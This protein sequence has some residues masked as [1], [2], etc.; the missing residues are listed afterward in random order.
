[1]ISPELLRRYPFFSSLSEVQLAEI[2]MISEEV[3][4]K[5]GETLLIENQPANTL[6]LLI[7]GSVDLIIK[8]E[9]EYHPSQHKEFTVGEINPGEIF[10]ISA[11]A[12]TLSYD[13]TAK[14]SRDSQVI[15][16]DAEAL[17]ALM[18]DDVVLANHLLEQTIQGLMERL[19]STRVQLA[20]AW[21]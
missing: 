13:A 2:A 7:N 9:E 20:A 12:E 8:S 5:N 11:M 6:Y 19:R 16:I 18:K 10:G 1:M 17:R 3:D 14:T 21:A 15:K 4:C